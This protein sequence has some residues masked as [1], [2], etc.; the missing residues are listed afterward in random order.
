MWSPSLVY[1]C[2]FVECFFP[3]CVFFL[4]LFIVI[5]LFN[6][7]LFRWKSWMC[8]SLGWPSCSSS[9]ASTRCPASRRSSSTR[10]PIQTVA[11]LFL[12]FR[13]VQERSRS[14][15]LGYSKHQIQHSYTIQYNCL[16]QGNG[17]IAS[18]VIYGVFSIASWLAPSAV[19][20]R[21]PRWAVLV[22]ETNYGCIAH[23]VSVWKVTLKVS[24]Q[25]WATLNLHLA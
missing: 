5:L 22:F 6:V 2:S 8:S 14:E 1:F 18:A 12:D 16:T 11:D 7:F 20:W 24:F 25:F 17:F 3:F 9:P 19:S 15:Y 10:P 4:L 21:G 23:I 13:S